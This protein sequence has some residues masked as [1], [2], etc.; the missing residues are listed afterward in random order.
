M[1]KKPNFKQN[2]RHMKNSQNNITWA[3]ILNY[4]SK[5]HVMDKH[6]TKINKIT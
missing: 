2:D 1:K 6:A 3:N 5:M 4:H